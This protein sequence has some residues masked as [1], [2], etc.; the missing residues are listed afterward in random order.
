MYTVK[1]L[2]RSKKEQS[3]SNPGSVVEGADLSATTETSGST[4][5]TVI[6]DERIP[7][8]VE[9]AFAL[10]TLFQA[11]KERIELLQ[12]VDARINLA[13]QMLGVEGREIVAGELGDDNPHLMLKAE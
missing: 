6:L 1:G 8:T 11:K 13:Y 9:Q 3:S 4:N 5:G 2:A 12:D 10:R 7:L